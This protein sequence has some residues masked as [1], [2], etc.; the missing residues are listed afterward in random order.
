M[1]K[2]GIKAERIDTLGNAVAGS[3][4]SVSHRGPFAPQVEFSEP[5]ANAGSE[6]L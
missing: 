5:A 2:L 4:Q 3:S 1:R 6:L